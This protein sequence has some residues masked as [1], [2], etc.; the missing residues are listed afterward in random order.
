[1]SVLTPE[2]LQYPT[3]AGPRNQPA[4]DSE[5]GREVNENPSHATE[6]ISNTPVSTIADGP[7]PGHIV[8]P[9][10]TKGWSYRRLFAKH[11]AGARSI[12]ICDPYVRM[13]FQARNLMEFLQM[14]HELVPEGD[15]VMVHL[16]TQSDIDSCVK[17]EENLNQLADSFS[18]SRVSFTWEFD[19][20]PNFH[21]RNIITDT[22]WK[23]TIDRG[24]DI[25]QKYATGPFSLEQT[26]QEARLTRGAEITYFK[27]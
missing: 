15:E 22:G 26:M 24:M 23:I 14:V 4:A 7:Q 1:M 17:Q 16:K 19:H 13:F 8:I 9:E 20:S 21:A 6:G 5:P 18:G 10:N 3:F 27:V 25:F 11:L 2:E 12:N